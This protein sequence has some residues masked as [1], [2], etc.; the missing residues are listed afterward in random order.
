MPSPDLKLCIVISQVG[1]KETEK[2]EGTEMPTGKKI[3]F[4]EIQ[5]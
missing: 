5:E 4:P 1:G 2:I 3:K